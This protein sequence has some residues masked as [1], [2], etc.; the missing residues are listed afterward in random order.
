M[1]KAVKRFYAAASVSEDGY[2]VLLDARTLRTPAENLFRAPSKALATAVAAEWQAQGASIAPA[3][4][5][6][7]QMAFAALDGG[8]AARAERIAYVC[9]FAETDLCCHRTEAPGELVLRQQET[10]DPL[11]DWGARELGI[12]LPVVT[13]VVAAYVPAEALAAL[14]ARV[15]AYDDFRLTALAHV[16]GL[17]GSALIAFALAEGWLDAEA[18]FAAAALDDLWSLERWG[19]DEEAW[20]RLEGLRVELRAAARF[21]LLLSA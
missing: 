5:P 7:T 21:V 12:R 4:M 6:L 1:S 13:G 19:E 11:V 3:A 17:S 16:A 20:E 9:K 15:E 8:A 2:G 14:R 10:W 18:A